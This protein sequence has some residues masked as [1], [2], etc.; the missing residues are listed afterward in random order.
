MFQYSAGV[1]AAPGFEIERARFARMLPLAEGFEAI[2]AHLR[3]L[4]RPRQA[5]CACELRSPAPFTERDF[6]AFNTQ[7]VQP[8][9]R[10]GIF[11]DGLNPV[12]RTNVC[13]AIG[14]PSEPSL[15]A[16]SYTVPAAERA[17]ASFVV[18]GSGEAPEGL[19]NYRDHVICLGDHSP[20]GLREK[21]KW[22]LAE[23]E[24]R[25]FTMGF[26]WQRATGTHLYTIYDVHPFL[27]EEIIA[28]NAAPGGLTWHFARPPVDKLDFEMDVRGIAREQVI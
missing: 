18:A 24:R 5:L 14:A 12:A 13:P 20:E 28:R 23:M 7:Y 2:E 26:D 1:A 9:M 11:R 17:E 22:V 6:S 4:G 8:L 19:D 15:Y 10:W 27:A 25:M 16:F 21:A 3:D